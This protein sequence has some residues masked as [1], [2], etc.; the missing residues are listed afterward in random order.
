MGATGK[1]IHSSS[2]ALNTACT[3]SYNVARRH[4]INLQDSTGPLG[5]AVNKNRARLSGLYITL[6]TLSA[7]PAPTSITMRL[8]RDAAG[9][10]PFIGDSTATISTGVTTATDGFVTYK[11]DIDYVHTD[12]I[13]WAFWKCDA[14]SCQVRRIELTWEE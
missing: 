14:G 9:D 5:T 10:E 2:H 7:A 13:I 3:T 12:S 4:Q 8:C 11:L 6:D 1:F